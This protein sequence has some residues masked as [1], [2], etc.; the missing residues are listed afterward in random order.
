MSRDQA[1]YLAQ[2][3]RLGGYV[4]KT[5]VMEDGRLYVRWTY[6]GQQHTEYVA[7]DRG[8]V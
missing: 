3:K 8:R 7:A 5:R 2:I 4:A 6:N 1:L